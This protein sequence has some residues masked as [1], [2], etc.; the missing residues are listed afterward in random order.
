MKNFIVIDS[1]TKEVIVSYNDEETNVKNGYNILIEDKD[2]PFQFG[3]RDN[4]KFFIC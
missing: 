2:K 1:E 3:T 4:K